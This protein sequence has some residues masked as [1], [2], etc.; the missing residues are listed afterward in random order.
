MLLGP[1]QVGKT[2]LLLQVADDLLARGWPPQNLTYFDFSD[3]R[4][5]EELTPRVIASAVP[6][7]SDPAHPRALLLDEVG[8][9]GP[10]DRWLKQAVDQGGCRIVVTDSS[11]KLLR[12]GSRESG[13]GRW[14]ELSIEG[15]SLREFT[16]LNARAEQGVDEAIR[17]MPD[18]LERFLALGGFPEHARSDDFPEVRAR[19][20]ADIVDR[21]IAR[22]LS[23]LERD[24]QRAKDLF[25]YLVQ[26][27][28][29][30]FTA[31]ARSADLGADPRTVRAW[32]ELLTE[33]LLL[34]ELERLTR[35][36]SA[37]LRSKVK[38]FAADHGLVQAFA[39]SPREV[40]LRARLFE[41]TVFRHLRPAVRELRG[42]LHYFRTPA[43]EELDFV[44]ELPAARIG[45]EV[46][47]SNRR[48]PE[49][50]V[51]TVRAGRAFGADRLL[52]VHG[53]VL[54]A[55]G[56]DE[57]VQQVPLLR[58]LFDTQAILRGEAR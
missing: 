54:E 48:R 41:A 4:I 49:K 51:E 9:A 3:E 34:S 16:R 52:L 18:L 20:R 13:Q 33:S 8:K 29:A 5:V 11:A 19:L 40:R 32:K 25:V 35:K 31:E 38:V 42:A 58:F 24:V 39:P 6:V 30:E 43:G 26:D 28:G 57:G 36:P 14:D 17:S 10:W 46:T 7:G 53:G 23:V 22:D 44:V 45:I 37:R 2:V 50:L 12:D 27:S 1:R 55:G 15:L 47:S 56:E 21:A